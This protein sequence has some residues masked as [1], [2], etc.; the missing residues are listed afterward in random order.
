MCKRT[1]RLLAMPSNSTR[2]ESPAA[3]KTCRPTICAGSNGSNSRANCAYPAPR[4]AS[5]PDPPHSFSAGSAACSR[6]SQ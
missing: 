2:S 4:R 5:P 6:D 3:R 1:N